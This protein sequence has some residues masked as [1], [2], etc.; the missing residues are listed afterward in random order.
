MNRERNPER[1]K[2]LKHSRI[3]RFDIQHPV[4]PESRAFL[5]SQRSLVQLAWIVHWG[6]V[7]VKSHPE[8]KVSAIAFIN[9][10]KS[11]PMVRSP[12]YA[13]FV[14]TMVFAAF[15]SA[16]AE[17][18]VAD[19]VQMLPSGA[20]SVAIVRLSQ[21]LESKRAVEEGWEETLEERFLSGAA[22]IPP[23]IDNL[24]VGS[25][26][27]LTIP[28]EVWSASLF[29]LPEGVTLKQI[30]ENHSSQVE[31][32]GR[33]DSVRLDRG[34]YI[35][36]VNEDLVG[37]YVPAHRQDAAR[38]FESV[39]QR[40]KS[41]SSTYLTQASEIDSHILMAIDLKEMVDPTMLRRK[42][43]E[44]SR[45][46]KYASLADKLV[47]LIAGI[48]GATLTINFDQSIAAELTLD[49]NNSVGD[50]VFSIKSVLIA[51][52]EDL[53]ASIEEFASAQATA[54]GKSVVLTCELSEAS[55]RQIISLISLP[56]Q[57]G[58]TPPAPEP[59]ITKTIRNSPVKDSA[60]A[61][62]DYVEAVN[63]MIDDLEKANR[64]ATNYERTILWHEKFADKID[65]LDRT[66]V[67]PAA[68]EYGAKIADAFRAL[69]ASL[70]GQAVEVD[71]QQRSIVYNRQYDPGWVSAN[72]WGGVGVRNASVNVTSNLE[73]V[74][75]KQADAVAAGS[76][77]RIAIWNMIQNERARISRRSE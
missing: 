54:S 26:I 7:E 61:T 55:F 46:T 11:S 1:F 70:R 41:P 6:L 50:S 14:T 67:Y 68:L 56:P 66:N 34:A 23:H 5:A 77:D 25:L 12:L 16:R 10:G 49:F 13:V 21:I 30:A 35:A 57:P 44:E 31:K 39:S 19:S 27:H 65:D 45:F 69:A 58:T 40:M 32:L 64:R 71:A 53:G 37:V 63:K 2:L 72:V 43:Q 74:R 18:T 4:P 36:A 28:E 62:A 20:N 29:P 33:R 52:L 17:T 3:P 24:V 22:A 38:W 60:E 42:L 73:E 76:K 51:V 59:A 47:P 48:Q 75:R 9:P 15:D 8:T